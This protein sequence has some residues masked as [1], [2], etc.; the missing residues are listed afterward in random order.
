MRVVKERIRRAGLTKETFYDGLINE[1]ML[2]RALIKVEGSYTL[3][4]STIPYIH[5]DTPQGYFVIE[6]YI[7]PKLKLPDE[8]DASEWDLSPTPSVSIL[9]ESQRRGRNYRYHC[10][11]NIIEQL[12]RDS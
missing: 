7:P 10:I 12:I 3:V 4:P 6:I 1:D 2:I 11:L 9:Y 5:V 8:R